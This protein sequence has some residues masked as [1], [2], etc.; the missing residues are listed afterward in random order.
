M[1]YGIGTIK[2]ENL[3]K[4]IMS[5]IWS[6]GHWV[7]G[8][9]GD[10]ETDVKLF[11]KM[12][13]EE[14]MTALLIMAKAL[15]TDEVNIKHPTLYHDATLAAI[16]EEIYGRIQ[17]EID[18]E[19]D[20]EIDCDFFINRR[21][22]RNAQIEYYKEVAEEIT[23]TEEERKQRIKEMIEDLPDEKSQDYDEW[24]RIVR[25][26]IDERLQEDDDYMIE[27]LHP[28]DD[29]ELKTNF[30]VKLEAR[31]VINQALSININQDNIN[32]EIQKGMIEDIIQTKLTEMSREI[33]PEE[34]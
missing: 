22:I 6:L 4:V 27:E 18:N 15:L 2:E 1:Y 34:W 3:K 26:Q 25:G 17:E 31:L 32:S 11:N 20:G 10:Y 13:T 7:E 28:E 21:L 16:I 5:A 9:E 8:L 24:E 12:T 33:N 23:D 29:V 30:H 19:K 14:K